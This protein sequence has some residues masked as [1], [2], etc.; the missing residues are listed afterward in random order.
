MCETLVVDQ[1]DRIDK[2]LAS[3][4]PH[5]RSLI[6]DFIKQGR[7]FEG[8]VPVNDKS[9]TVEKG[10]SIEVV[11]PDNDSEG[12][13]KPEG[14]PLEVL[15]KDEYLLA[16]N[17]P[18]GIIVHPAGVAGSKNARFSGT[19]VNR[20]LY[21]YPRLAEV[22]SRRRAGLVH[23]LDKGTSGVILVARQDKILK[24]LQDQFKQKL[25]D[26]TYRAISCGQLSETS[27]QVEVPLG[28]K[29][30]NPLLRQPDPAGKSATTKFIKKGAGVGRVALKCLPVTGR[31]HQIR[32]H[33]NYLN[34]P[35]L[36]DKKYGGE[37]AERLMLHAEKIEFTHPVKSEKI[38]VNSSPPEVFEKR[39]T[40]LTG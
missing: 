7:V 17:K 3:Q 5:S 30:N 34:L 36:G 4:L 22:D 21:Y 12:D 38:L 11:F 23:R 15:Y 20:L 35:V 24:Q 16:V 2:Y 25:V 32:V 10:D 40:S 1:T 19:L 37:P 13:I 18:S 14:K 33:L 28:P 9:L 39:W 31:T 27:V 8:G 26:K 6:Q 29:N